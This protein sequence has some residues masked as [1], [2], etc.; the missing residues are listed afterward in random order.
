MISRKAPQPRNGLA[1]R[2]DAFADARNLTCQDMLNLQSADIQN[3]E[4][5]SCARRWAQL[6]SECCLAATGR[7]PVSAGGSYR[8]HRSRTRYFQGFAWRSAAADFRGMRRSFS[9]ASAVL[10]A[11]LWVALSLAPVPA[12]ASPAVSGTWRAEWPDT[13][14]TKRTI[15]LSEIRSGGPPKDGIPSIDD[16]QFIPTA[17]AADLTATEPVIALSIGG[18]ARAYPLRVLTWHEIVN[19]TVGGVPVAVTYCPLCNAAIAF[20]RQIDGRVLDFGTTGELRHSDLVM[21]DRQTK[22]WWQQ[23]TGTA[24]VGALAGLELKML[25]VRLETFE[26]FQVRH[27]EARVLIPNDPAKR[28]YGANP[29][30]G[31]DRSR[32][33]FLYDGSFPEGIAPM[34]YVVAVDDEAWSLDLLRERG[35]IE[36]GDLQITWEPGQN[37]ALDTSIISEGRDIGNVVVRRRGADGTVEIPHHVTFAFVFHAFQP[38]GRLHT[39]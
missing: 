29:Y 38:E 16:P 30:V 8:L 33:P 11:S 22:S 10:V 19:D 35:R 12:I 34:A 1:S 23:Y 36:A 24:I 39:D 4:S 13:D 26:R 18:D 3:C 27:P 21:Y 28:P 31:Y 37:S 15:D 17:E 32:L 25:P 5:T 7:T 2:D 6:K 14:F 9:I 20:E